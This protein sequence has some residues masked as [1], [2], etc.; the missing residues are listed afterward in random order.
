MYKTIML[1]LIY[2]FSL[3]FVEGFGGLGVDLGADFEAA[4]GAGL[5]AGLEVALGA[6]LDLFE[7]M[8]SLSEDFFFA[9]CS[10]RISSHSMLFGLYLAGPLGTLAFLLFCHSEHIEIFSKENSL[11]I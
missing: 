6:N 3:L 2:I 11:Y 8:F 10:R 9:S 4:L 1:K 5:A 7:R